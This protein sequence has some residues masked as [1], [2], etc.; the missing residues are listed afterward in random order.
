MG[1][2]ATEAG[3]A[4]LDRYHL[5][6]Y[7]IKPP[8]LRTLPIPTA[9]ADD[10]DDDEDDNERTTSHDN[11][12]MMDAFLSL[13]SSTAVTHRNVISSWNCLPQE[14]PALPSS[15][16][17]SPS[18][19]FTVTASIPAPKFAGETL[20]QR[21]HSLID[22]A[23]DNWNYAIFWQL[24]PAAAGVALTWGDGY[25]R[26]LDEDNRVL[27]RRKGKTGVRAEPS[28]EVNSF[29]SGGSGN[30]SA[31]E[32][33]TD[34]EWFFLVSMTQTLAPGSGLPGQTLLT[35]SPAWLTTEEVLEADPCERAMLARVFG[36][37]TMACVPLPCG[38]VVEVGSTQ[39]IYQNVDFLNKIRELFHGRTATTSWQPSV[40]HGA[41]QEPCDLYISEP[42]ASKP[43]NSS[44]NVAISP[45][46]GGADS[47]CTD[48][49]ISH[50]IK[51]SSSSND[52]DDWFLSTPI[53][54][55]K[56][57][58]LLDCIAGDSSDRY[59][60]MQASVREV[61]RSTA[62]M[63]PAY[64]RPKKRGRKP[65]NGRE[66]SVD[67]LEAERQRRKKLNQRF[68]S[69]RS[70]V[71]H[72][73][74]MD[75]ASLLADAVAYINELRSKAKALDAD[76]RRLLAELAELEVNKETAT[77]A[78]GS[79]TPTNPPPGSM[80]RC[81]DA[82]MEVEVK[83]FGRE[84]IV[85]VQSDWQRHP[86]ARLMAALRELEL[87]VNC[88]NVSVVKELMMQQ[89]TVKMTNR[90]YTQEQLTA[91]LFAAVGIAGET[92]RSQT[93]S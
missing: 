60:D 4:L 1:R 50:E 46:G 57:E 17:S 31:D 14:P 44:V 61:T 8:P 90:V 47:L 32:K 21:L 51:K 34:T 38:A 59:S 71:P 39:E 84:A 79:Q 10:D 11:A 9:A 25:Y 36:F 93:S 86:A 22:G 73:S 70:V 55:V 78:T 6:N 7:V 49:Y 53:A 92:C 83:I 23:S 33:V 80:V 15:S 28:L 81:S 45:T 91:A 43:S 48:K 87:E 26:G 64:N 30:D 69:L 67:H 85:R 16:S 89:V 62:L 5:G 58:G 3:R 40:E 42:S 65:A 74:K 66:E 52:D 18:S 12:S 35:G 27:H 41:L 82:L 13:S 72:V 88:A 24:S 37:R 56:L 54:A 19:H 68:Y 76:K 63:D 75:K 77:A 2:P 29:M 20:Q